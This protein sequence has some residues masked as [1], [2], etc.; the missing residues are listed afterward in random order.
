MTSGPFLPAAQE[1]DDDDDN[2]QGEEE[3]HQER[4]NNFPH[5]WIGEEVSSERKV[6]Y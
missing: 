5:V 4:M 1:D 3:D 2:N 6:F